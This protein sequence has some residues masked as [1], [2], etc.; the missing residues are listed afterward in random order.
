MTDAAQ[1]RPDGVLPPPGG[2]H[3]PAVGYETSDADA[4]GVLWFAGALAAT[5]AVVLAVLVGVFSAFQARADRRAATRFPLSAPERVP[6]PQTTF[7]APVTGVLPQQPQLDGLDLQPPQPRHEVGRN[8]VERI[9]QAM[10]LVA[11]ESKPKGHEPAPVR[12]DQG[13]P[14]TGGGSNSGRDLLEAKR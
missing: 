1:S 4:R 7:G 10:R 5:I 13:I 8:R 6:L 14:G 11:E 12:Y 3:T 9:E 2:A